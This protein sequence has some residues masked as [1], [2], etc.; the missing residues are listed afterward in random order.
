[1]YTPVNKHTHTHTTHT[2]H[3][4]THHSPC[5]E[6]Y[7][8]SP[9]HIKPPPHSASCKCANFYTCVHI[10]V[11]VR[12]VE[13]KHH[14]TSASCKGQWQHGCKS[15]LHISICTSWYKIN[16]TPVQVAG[17]AHFKC[18]WGLCA[19]WCQENTTSASCRGS[20]ASWA[21]VGVGCSTNCSLWC[22]SNSTIVLS[23]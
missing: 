9:P 5:I 16:A 3:T 8:K 20:R 21:L 14:H 7:I 6:H 19:N 1:M 15:Y 10:I 2:T 17:D 23:M 13:E 18:K 22:L 4:H 12:L 11:N